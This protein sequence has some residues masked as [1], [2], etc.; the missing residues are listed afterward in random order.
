MLSPNNINYNINYNIRLLQSNIPTTKILNHINNLSKQLFNTIPS[1]IN[2]KNKL[3]LKNHKLNHILHQNTKW[4]IDNNYKLKNNI[5]IIEKHKQ[6]DNTNP[7]IL[8]N[9]TRQQKHPQLNSLNSKNHFYKITII[10]KIYNKT[11]TK[12]IHLTKK[13]LT[14]IIHSKNHKL[15]Y[16]IYQNS[17]QKILKTSTTY[18]ITLPNHQ[19]YTTPLNNPKTKKYFTTITYTINYTFTN[20]QIITHFI[21]KTFQSFFNQKHETLKLSLIYNIYHNITK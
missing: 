11:T 20:H 17:L 7:T 18:K 13:N 1:N 4:T 3:K 2:K 6:F 21:H 19:L 16:Q 12:T 5:D 14:I 10:T 9:Q 8:S 15:D